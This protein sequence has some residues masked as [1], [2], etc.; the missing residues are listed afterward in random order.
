MLENLGQGGKYSK[1]EKDQ[2]KLDT[3]RMLQ[4]AAFWRKVGEEYQSPLIVTGRLGFESPGPNGVES[5]ARNKAM[6]APR[7]TGR[8]MLEMLAQPLDS[9]RSVLARK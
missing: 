4:D 8:P 7:V 2:F 1:A 6:Y 5:V 9:P 3:D